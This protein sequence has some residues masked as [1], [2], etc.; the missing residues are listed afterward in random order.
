MFGFLFIITFSSSIEINN[1]ETQSIRSSTLQRPPEKHVYMFVTQRK[2]IGSMEGEAAFKN[3]FHLRQS[4]Q[5]LGSNTDGSGERMC[6]KC[7]GFC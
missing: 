4:L 2:L 5:G 3:P 7:L 1:I 6:C